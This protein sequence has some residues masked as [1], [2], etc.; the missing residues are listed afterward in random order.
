[1]LLNWNFNN[2]YLKLPENFYSFVKADIFPQ[3]KIALF[4][5]E[6]S[7]NLNLQLSNTN[8]HDLALILSGQKKLK[9]VYF[10]H[11]LMPVINLVTLQF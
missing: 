2:S 5:K 1:M 10:F 7:E 4:N 11:K 6:L 8:D 9:E 3:P